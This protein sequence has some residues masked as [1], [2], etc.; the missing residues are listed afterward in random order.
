MRRRPVGGRL[1]AMKKVKPPPRQKKSPPFDW[2]AFCEQQATKRNPSKP[3]SSA[4]DAIKAE[5]EKP[6]MTKSA[7]ERLKTF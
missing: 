2:A 1:S 3:R 5:M 4:L 7:R 6:A